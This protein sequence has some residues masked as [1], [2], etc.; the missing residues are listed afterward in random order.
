ME[1]RASSR[2]EV[3]QVER[4]LKEQGLS[5]EEMA[6]EMPAKKKK[7]M[8]LEGRSRAFTSTTMVQAGA[9]ERYPG[10][11]VQPSPPCTLQALA[12]AKLNEV[13]VTISAPYGF[14]GDHWN[15]GEYAFFWVNITNTSGCILREV[16]S[17][18]DAYGWARIAPIFYQ[19]EFYCA[20]EEYWEKIDIGETVGFPVRVGTAGAGNARLRVGLAAEVIPYAKSDL[21][22]R[23]DTI[24]PS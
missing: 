17:Y 16:Y 1:Q 14:R 18:V 2:E 6:K 3:D 13:T 7:I 5:L 11:A 20:G 10:I 19:G 21:A 15:D 12:L 9:I 8:A 22:L 4:I 23:D 24:W